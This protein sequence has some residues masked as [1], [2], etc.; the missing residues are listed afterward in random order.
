MKFTV[1]CF[2]KG[3]DYYFVSSIDRQVVG[4]FKDI[5]SF[6]SSI[7]HELKSRIRNIIHM[8][9]VF[10]VMIFVRTISKKDNHEVSSVCEDVL[11]MVNNRITAIVVDSFDCLP[12]NKG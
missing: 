2:M 8:M 7:Y 10:G 12:V 4:P 9:R 11:F 6:I 1:L 3:N 5:Q